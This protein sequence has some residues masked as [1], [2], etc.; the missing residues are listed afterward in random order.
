M[1]DGAAGCSHEQ[2]LN[3][4]GPMPPY[5]EEETELEKAAAQ[6]GKKHRKK[7]GKAARAAEFQPKQN[8]RKNRGRKR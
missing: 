7:A 2:Q 6:W 1:R 3:P 8:V 5:S 4:S